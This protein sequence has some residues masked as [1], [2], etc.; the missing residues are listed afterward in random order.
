MEKLN[1]IKTLK[2]IVKVLQTQCRSISFLSY[3]KAVDGKCSLPVFLNLK[4]RFENPISCIGFC[5]V[6]YKE[7]ITWK[8][9]S[10]SEVWQVASF[11]LVVLSCASCPPQKR[12]LMKGL[13]VTLTLQSLILRLQ[14]LQ[15]Y[16][17]I[18]C[19]G[20]GEQFLIFSWIV[21]V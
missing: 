8:L 18:F 4:S 7:Q 11:F 14:G 21:F 10:V 9:K 5:K 3:S 15:M 2:F 16:R 13:C 20:L 17:F 19:F 6:F 12:G 1:K